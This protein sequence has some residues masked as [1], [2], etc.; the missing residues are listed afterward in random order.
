MK[1]KHVYGNVL[2]L[3]IPLTIKIRTLENGEPVEREEPFMPDAS[4][5]CKVTLANA[6]SRRTDYAPTVDGNVLHIEDHGKLAIG[7][8]GVT[9][10][11]Y[12]SSGTPYRYMARCVVEVCDATIDAD[13][14]AG[15]EFDAETYTLEGAVF[16]S[17]GGAQV[18]SDWAETDPE[19]KSFIKNKP[20]FDAAYAP[21]DE[22][23]EVAGVEVMS[24][25]DVDGMIRRI[26][27]GS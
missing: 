20:D 4:R 24:D 8:Y 6:Y 13:I 10:S 7:T 17:Y 12:D 1:I 5:P 19:E 18:Q 9:V 2:K 16:V 3:D 14:E 27:G 15:V 21:K 22:F 25:A 11:C 26:I 23:D